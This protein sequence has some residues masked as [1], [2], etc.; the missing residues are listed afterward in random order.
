MFRFVPFD[1]LTG[2]I[3]AKNSEIALAFYGDIRKF[4]EIEPA[5]RGL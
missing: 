3:L 1:T 5:I 4:G 2:I